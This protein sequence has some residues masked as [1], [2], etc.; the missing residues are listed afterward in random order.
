LRRRSVIQS[1]FA[2]LLF[3][4]LA[5]FKLDDRIEKKEGSMETN[6]K[7]KFWKMGYNFPFVIICMIL[8]LLTALVRYALHVQ[9]I[10]NY[11]HAL[12]ISG[13]PFEWN[14]GSV[15]LDLVFLSISVT[16]IITVYILLRCTLGELPK[17][18]KI[19]DQ[20]LKGNHSARFII[21]DDSPMA[22]LANKLNKLLESLDKKNKG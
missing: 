16:L 4:L 3:F 9:I 19:L 7:P 14:L 2:E 15:G 10:R 13:I 21:E 6:N 17:L 12:D 22:P 1:E 8:M 5:I 18:E 20:I 11:R